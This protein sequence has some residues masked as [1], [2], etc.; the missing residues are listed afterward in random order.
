MNLQSGVGARWWSVRRST[1]LRWTGCCAVLL[2]TNLC[3][4]LPPADGGPL[5]DRFKSMFSTDYPVGSEEWWDE[6]KKKAVLVPGKG[7]QVEGYDGYFDQK[8]R[9]IQQAVERDDIAE[10]D[11]VGIFPGLSP[12]VVYT[13]A[14]SAVG[15][16][17]DQQIAKELFDEAEGY[18]AEGKYFKAAWHYKDAALRWPN[19]ALEEDALFMVGESR[20]F[21]D[22]YPSARNAYDKAVAK[23]PNTRHLNTIVERQWA[24]A[25]YWEHVYFDGFKMPLSPNTYDKKRPTFDTIGH[26]IKTYDSIRLNDPTGPRADDAIIATAG[27]YFRR[28]R[29]EDADF[30]YTLLRNEYPRSDFQYEAHLLGLQSKMRKYQGPDYD[31]AALEEA[32]K[33]AK[34]L[35][36]QFG[37]QLTAE[38]KERLRDVGAELNRQIALR[39]IEMATYNDNKKYYLAAR[40]YYQRVIEQYPDSPLAE[41][42]RVRLAEIGDEPDVPPERLAWFLELVPQSR[43]RTRVARIPELQR[44]G[45]LVAKNPQQSGESE[46]DVTP[47]AGTTVR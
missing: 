40:H 8:G 14:K 38:E 29:Y 6:H 5:A 36:T 33:L 24:I 18:F 47:A 2:A 13:R 22:D 39:D 28:L 26:A 12:E 42:A 9:P 3:G 1:R 35:R 4:L 7:Y 34:Q 44:G 43:E 21:D 20:F 19:S 25:Q 45:T 46:E 27:I 10:K 15:L 30:H 37:H 32:Q 11:E 23:F 31:G 16:G 17:R 41:Q